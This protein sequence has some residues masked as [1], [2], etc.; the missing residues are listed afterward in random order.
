MNVINSSIIDKL[1]G[2]SLKA[3]SFRGVMVLATSTVVERALRLIR[4]MI[5][6][7]LLAP[8]DFGLMAIVIA[9]SAAFEAFADVGVRLSIIQNKRGADREYLNVAWWVQALRGLGLC[10]IGYLA[11]PWIS[12]FYENAELLPLMRLAFVAVFLRSLVSPRAYVLEKEMRFGKYV[13]MTQGSGLLGT[14]V[15]VGLVLFVVRNIWALLIGFVVEGASVFLLSFVLC[16]FLPRLSIDRRSLSSILKYAR[17]VFGL[18][19]LTIVTLQTD[20]VVLGKFVSTERLGMYVLALALAQQPAWMFGHVIGR[21]LFPVFTK[22]Q[23]DKEALCRAVLKMIRVTVVLGVPLAALAAIVAGPI[24]SVVYGHRYAAV[25][26]LFG[27]L[28]VTM[29][30][31][32]QGI[33]LAGIYLAIG[34]PHLH[35]RFVIL[36]AIIIISLIYPGIALFGLPGAAGVLLVSN[37][38]A[39]FM[40]VIWMRKQIGLRFKDY[41]ACWISCGRWC[42]DPGVHMGAHES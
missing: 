41:I 27:I 25:A 5:L 21:V 15:T 22:K 32:V 38:F 3:R 39:V 9:A 19:L 36:L 8:D 33:V 34:K 31:R 23:D 30:F 26:T 24:L 37:I 16:P 14:I 40:Q 28:C 13:F 17:G 4:N 12:Q 11:S 7:R 35:R 10:A 2:N 6:A 42:E 18:S 1:R 20:V 29:L